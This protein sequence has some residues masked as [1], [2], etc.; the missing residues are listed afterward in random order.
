MAVWICHL[1]VHREVL[2]PAAN[3]FAGG[4]AG[5]D[6]AGGGVLGM[7]HSWN[8]GEEVSHPLPLHQGNLTWIW[9]KQSKIYRAVALEERQTVKSFERRLNRERAPS[10]FK[11]EPSIL[12]LVEIY[13]SDQI[14]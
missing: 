1:C 8:Y 13:D 2:L 7:Q 10:P 6:G 11:D 12:T 3:L 5:E 9:E 14:L 4:E